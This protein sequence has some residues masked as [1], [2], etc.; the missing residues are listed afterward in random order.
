MGVVDV[1]HDISRIRLVDADIVI[2]TSCEHM[3]NIEN[4]RVKNQ[5]AVYAFQ[6]C[7]EES[8]PG[9]VN[10]ARSTDEFVEQCQFSTVLMRG[11]LNLGHKNRFMVIGVKQ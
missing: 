9:H 4:I 11:R 5:S 10:I 3:T 8:D 7:D 6:S 1:E 2:N